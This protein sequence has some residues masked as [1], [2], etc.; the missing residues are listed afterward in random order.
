[1]V[2]YLHSFRSHLSVTVWN[3]Q[4]CFIQNLLMNESM[5]LQMKDELH[6]ESGVLFFYSVLFVFLW[7]WESMNGAQT[8]VLVFAQWTLSLYSWSQKRASVYG[9]NKTQT[10][11]PALSKRYI[12]PSQCQ[13][14]FVF[15]K[16]NFRYNL[17][18]V[19]FEKQLVGKHF[20]LYEEKHENKMQ[21]KY[22]N[23]IF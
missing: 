17:A 18:G 16:L 8:L 5:K 9:A 7:V 14:D 22:L 2:Q 11:L 15:Y 4:V 6:D 13:C 1:M 3:I 21:Q 12:L 10:S 19:V 20:Q 23:C